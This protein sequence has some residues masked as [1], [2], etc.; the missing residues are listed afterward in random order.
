MVDIVKRHVGSGVKVYVPDPGVKIAFPEPE[1]TL[2]PVI[3][4]SPVL[5]QIVFVQQLLLHH[6]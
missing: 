4:I 6:R 3:G 5:A 2:L 1:R